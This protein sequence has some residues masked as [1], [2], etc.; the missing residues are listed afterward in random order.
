MASTP[1][2]NASLITRYTGNCIRRYTCPC[3]V[4]QVCSKGSPPTHS[5]QHTPCSAI[6]RQSA[7]QYFS[8]P[9]PP[10]NAM[11]SYYV[12]DVASSAQQWPIIN[13]LPWAARLSARKPCLFRHAGKLRTVTAV[14]S[15]AS[16]HKHVIKPN[17][18]QRLVYAQSAVHNVRT[19]TWYIEQLDVGVQYA[20]PTTTRFFILAFS[21]YCFVNVLYFD[22]Y[23][24]GLV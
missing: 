19:G 10:C 23:F 15:P 5:T 18:R 14:G 13:F 20:C 2:L 12:A 22:R 3:P 24:D 7:L 9:A 8:Y 16:E 11:P 21:L 4:S 6:Y 1:T 17:L